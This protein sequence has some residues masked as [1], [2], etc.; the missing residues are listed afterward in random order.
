MVIDQ[1]RY[2][3]ST[4]FLSAGGGANIQTLKD[5]DGHHDLKIEPANEAG[6]VIMQISARYGDL[7]HFCSLATMT[8]NNSTRSRYLPKW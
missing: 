6:G 2:L 7:L 4:W 3:H 5:T 1:T 8:Y